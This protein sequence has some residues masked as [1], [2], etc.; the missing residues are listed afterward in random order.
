MSGA[1]LTYELSGADFASVAGGIAGE[2]GFFLSGPSSATVELGGVNTYSGI[3]TV[4]YGTLRLGANGAFSPASIFNIYDYGTLDL[5]GRDHTFTSARFNGST[6]AVVNGRAGVPLTVTLDAA[7]H[8]GP[9]LTVSFRNGASSIALRKT[10]AGTLRLGG[11]STAT[12]G[13]TVEA[14]TLELAGE[15]NGVGTIIGGLT[16]LRGARV[17]TVVPSALGWSAGAK[18]DRVL[19]KDGGAL[20]NAVNADQSWAVAFTLDNGGILSS[21]GGVSSPTTPSRYTFGSLWDNRVSVRATGAA[22]SEIRGRVDL[23]P[24]YGQTLVD[25][26]VD[27]GSSLLVSAAVTSAE[28]PVGLR[29]LGAG[30]LALTAANPYSGGT[31]VD[32]GTLELEG[33]STSGEGVIRGAL[34]LQPGATA[35]AKSPLALGTAPGAS[36]ESITLNGNSTLRNVAGAQG[37]GVAYALNGGRL[38]SNEGVS[39]ADASSFFSFGGPSGRPTS[40]T[41]GASSSI[42]GR[43]DLRPDN[44]HSVTELQVGAGATLS[45]SAALTGSGGLRKTGP[46]TLSL[47]SANTYSGDTLIEAGTL[48]L[49]TG[50]NLGASA[51]VSIAAGATL[52]ASATSGLALGPVSGAGTLL[53]G[54]SVALSAPAGAATSFS[55][56]LSGG[57]VL[58]KTG[59]GSV[60]LSGNNSF[61]GAISVEA[62]TLALVS[63]GALSPAASLAIASGAVF[64]VSAKFDTTFSSLSGAGRLILGANSGTFEQSTDTTFS[65]TITGLGRF[66]KAGSGTLVLTGNNPF[67]GAAFANG[68][69]LVFSSGQSIGTSPIFQFGG[70][71]LR[72]A[73]GNTY[74][75][76]QRFIRFNATGTLDVGANDV[77]FANPIGTHQNGTIGVGGLVK[78]G[79]G[80]LTLSGVNTYAGG[81]VVA[82]GTLRLAAG[83][84]L[85][86]GRSLSVAP[87][88]TLDLS[89]YGAAGY[90]LPA[91]S[92]FEN[93][94]TILGLLRIADSSPSLVVEQP[95]NTALAAGATVDFG[96][97][98]VGA[99]QLAR[100]FTVRNRGPGVLNVSSLGVGG[101]SPADFVLD[102]SAFS[103]VLGPGQSTTFTLRFA[104]VA[105]GLRTASLTLASDDPAA[106]SFTLLL[107]GRGGTPRLSVLSPSGAIVATDCGL[108]AWGLNSSGQST[109][110]PTSLV[111]AVAAGG[112]HNLARMSDGTVIAWGEN[113]SQQAT[114]PSGLSGVAA[115]AAGDSHS[116]ALKADGTLVAWG[117]NAYGQR[118]VPA[119]L[120]SVV[121][122]A[123][124]G[125]HNLALRA[126]ATVVGW[127][128]DNAGQATAPA[129]LSGIVAIAAGGYHS[130]ALRSNGTVV[131]WG[132]NAEGQATV[133]SGLTGVVA[134]SAGVF[135][136]LALKADGSVVAW[137][138]NRN[139]QINLPAGLSGVA[140]ISAGGYHN[141]ALK[142]DGT[143]LAWG[144]GQ[145]Q[146]TT[147]P[148]GQTSL[149]SV[150]AGYYHSLALKA[151]APVDI[152]RVALGSAG[153]PHVLTL[154]NDGA[155]PLHLEAVTITG[156][157]A[158]EFTL[159]TAGLDTPL[160]PGESTSVSV[161]FHPQAVGARLAV[162]RITSDDPARKNLDVPLAATGFAAPRLVVE[163]ALGA[164]LA[165][166]AAI[167]FDPLAPATAGP[168]R[169]F[170]LRNRGS[171]PLTV[172]ALSLG[173]AH[174][175]DFILESLAAPAVLAPDDAL[176]FTLRFSPTADGA[177]SASLSIAS[178]DLAAP[179]F[180]LALSGVGL[181]PRQSWQLAH[182]GH[183]DGL[184]ES[185]DSA[186]P[187]GDGVPNLLE[188]AFGQNPLD[189]AS[190]RLPAIVLADAG[191][192]TE[193][194]LVC[195]FTPPAGVSGIRYAAEWSATLAPGGWLA[196]PDTGT[197]PRHTFRLPLA[198]RPRAFL[199]LVVE[200]VP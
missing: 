102:R 16:V 11:R 143:L 84:T 43:V 170:T 166:G 184:A 167:D 151:L 4:Q 46:G 168:V 193:T 90:T 161:T 190:A 121:A 2:G 35:V 22:R 85:G 27:S 135:H 116:L 140:S 162:V 103:P 83:A 91:G 197:A 74:D 88:A 1:T 109:V 56:V 183:V 142:S 53:L 44:G 113:I 112:Y 87:G 38:V 182:F 114:V 122:V 120:A 8:S 42:E 77:V 136:S 92:T 28:G 173:G 157:N 64:D 5:N 58:T 117:N 132:R 95:F 192:G 160:A 34:T 24:Q 66:L 194:A 196:V 80:I 180:T 146:Q 178:D 99:Q 153:T 100:T 33:S 127:G 79:S 57:G 75:L 111:A 189:P 172:S 86:T 89:A 54:S 163:S 59:A 137:G 129:G 164:A 195:D 126:D 177:R 10:G 45:V 134:I 70:G 96:A 19:L 39:R 105:L 159:H 148:A 123:A 68:G 25:F 17:T 158:G 106:P 65:G 101:V 67:G 188:Y 133:P 187:D 21:N 48:T 139:Q 14:G 12:G 150:S 7:D 130:L 13:T 186:D 55:G 20:E 37:W 174:A 149:T 200:S 171:A 3:T 97:L 47:R 29:K 185:A 49:A 94:G 145:Y 125:F 61:G 36:L 147:L 198:G 93:R 176:V 32:A 156:A 41:V 52:D 50:A 154:R 169:S 6:G 60:T 26:T 181:T 144:S 15:Q 115:V 82:A 9:P 63:A 118:T 165:S 31:F 199:R 71:T 76:S 155:G 72:W 108:A 23:S 30:T 62:G 175:G 98:D 18:I 131:A 51:S 107:S 179:A 152:G 78:A 141:L 191:D 124:G 81:T 104:P 69:V 128:F 138:D 40:F 110:P 119:G 73:P